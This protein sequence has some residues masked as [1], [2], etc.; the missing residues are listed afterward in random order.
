[1]K[2][3]NVWKIVMASICFIIACFSGCAATINYQDTTA[4]VSMVSNGASPL[5]ALCSIK[6]GTNSHSTLCLILAAN[7]R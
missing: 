2:E 3:S 5:E 4:V 6:D 1:M 7:K